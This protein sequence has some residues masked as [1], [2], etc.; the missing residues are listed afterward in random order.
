MLLEVIHLD[1]PGDVYSDL[2]ANTHMPLN[3]YC[4]S[5]SQVWLQH[6]DHPTEARILSELPPH[7]RGL[8]A[9]HITSELLEGSP[10]TAGLDQVVL[11]QLASRLVPVEVAP[12]EAGEYMWL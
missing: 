7:L 9:G 11:E 8:V 5:V 6:R 3:P 2:R 1:A 10:V 12:G 4:Y